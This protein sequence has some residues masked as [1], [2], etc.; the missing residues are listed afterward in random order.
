V[1]FEVPDGEIG[2]AGHFAFLDKGRGAGVSAGMYV[3]IYQKP[4]YLS[5]SSGDADLPEDWQGIAILRIIDV[6]DAGS[7]GYLVE[8]AQEVRIGDLT[9]RP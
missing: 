8:S 7:L 2:G 1:A 9:K 6:T 4:G 3:R 5:A